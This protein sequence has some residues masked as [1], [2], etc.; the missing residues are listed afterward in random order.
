MY[1]IKVRF[2]VRFEAEALVPPFTSKVSKTLL[3]K[4]LQASKLGDKLQLPDKGA[5]KPYA[6]TP[7]FAGDRALMKEEEGLEPP[8][9]V[10]PGEDYWFELRLVGSQAPALIGALASAPSLVEAFGSKALVAVDDLR[11]KSFDSM[12]M[13]DS[14][15]YKLSFLTPTL[16]K[17]PQPPELK[18]KCEAKHTLFPHSGLIAYSLASHWNKYSPDEHRVPSPETMATYAEHSLMEVDYRLRPF[19]AIYDERRRPRGF[20]GWTLYRHRKLDEEL[21]RQ[22]RKLLDY[23]NYVGIGRSRTTGFGVVRVEAR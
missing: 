8:L 15:L 6:V 12:G 18:G 7:L 3:V 20:I 9:T 1:A 17:V 4:L 14:S 13:P 22:L 2:R 21:D 10:R 16:L 23:A 11:F 19:T 5:R